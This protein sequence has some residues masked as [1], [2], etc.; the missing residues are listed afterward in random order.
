MLT[1][2]PFDWAT[3]VCGDKVSGAIG[4]AAGCGG[5]AVGSAAVSG[6]PGPPG[7]TVGG[8]T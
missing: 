7:P 6:T 3:T 4:W 8:M 2:T 1:P 5:G